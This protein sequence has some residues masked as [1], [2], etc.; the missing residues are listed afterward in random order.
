MTKMNE[1]LDA[2]EREILDRF[3][4]GE[5]R[6]VDDAGDEIETARRAA[7]ETLSKSRK[8]DPPMTEPNP[9]ISSSG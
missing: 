6:R 4:R 8:V 2:E 9:N 5:F 3:E 7:R 1:Q